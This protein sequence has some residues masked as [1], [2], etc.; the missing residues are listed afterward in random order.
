ME[1]HRVGDVVHGFE[2]ISLEPLEEYQAQGLSFKHRR[3]GCEIFHLFRD[4]PENFFAFVFKTPPPDNA[5]VPHILEHSVLSGSRRYPLKDPFQAMM[6]GSINSF[7]NAMTYSEKTVFPAASPSEKDYFNLF[8]VYA[9]SVFFPLLKKEIFQQEGYHLEWDGEKLNISGIV[10]SEMKGAYESHDTIVGE[11]SYRSLFPDT[12]YQF[13]SGGIPEAIPDLTYEKFLDFHRRC[14]HP[15]NCRVFLYG[16]IPTERQLALLEEEY[17]HEFKAAQW[18]PNIPSTPRWEAPRSFSTTSPL[19]RGE[20]ADGR[21]TIVMS[22]KGPPLRRPE[23]LLAMEVLSEILLGHVGAPLY[24]A[25]V[26]SG[27]GEDV[28]PV[29][30]LDSDLREA[31]FT[32]GLRGGRK[33]DEKTFENL[34]IST[35]T[36]LADGGIPEN[37]LRAG[38]HQVEFRN[39]EI[40][41]GVPFG[42]RLMDKTLPGWLHGG[43]PSEPL[44]FTASMEELKKAL[45]CEEDYFAN[46]IRRELLNNPHRST[47]VIIPDP[48]HQARLDEALEEKMGALR[49]SMSP[50]DFAN[51]KEEGER[52]ARFQASPDDE[53]AAALIPTLHREDLPRDI[54]LIDTSR[55]DLAGIPLYIHDLFTN[56]LVYIDI[57]FDLRGLTDEQALLLPLLSRLLCAA[58]LPEMKY[59][60]VANRLAM[61]SGGLYT[62]LEAGLNLGKPGENRE[63]LFFRLKSLEK[64]VDEALSLVKQLFL[65]GILTDEQRIR[66]ILLEQRNDFKSTIL[67]MG[68]T[69]TVL[70]GGAKL[71]P[72]N[73]REEQWRGV[74]QYLFLFD[75][76]KRLDRPGET[77]GIGAQLENI[78]RKIFTRK[79]MILN[80]T[81]AGESLSQAE[82]KASPF[83]ASFPVGSPVVPSVLSTLDPRGEK[84]IVPASVGYAGRIIPASLAGTETYA[85]E[86][87]AGHY[88]QTNGLWEEVRMKGGAYGVSAA[89]NGADGVFE[90]TSYRDPKPARTF[91]IFRE[92]LAD[93][94]EKAPP[95]EEMERAVIA[96]IG[97]DARPL[98]P[99]EKSLIGFR[100]SLYG[101]TDE[102]RRENR[103]RILSAGPEDLQKTAERLFSQW[104]EGISVLLAGAE[105]AES[106]SE[107]FPELSE[108][109]EIPF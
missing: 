80:I 81:A 79:R 37:L 46:L 44:R 75:T 27:I 39:R 52:L 8:R 50:R 76:A 101:I 92:A 68:H 60:E 83:V 47:V 70:R 57:A 84:L 97:R 13:D 55:K 54:S 41:G 35:L 23:N 20:A 40:K 93:M 53:A 104:E 96:V 18:T 66:D 36:N 85:H 43:K 77:A 105:L 4:D 9:D 15:S 62:S 34:V 14:Y 48:R 78:R 17:L 94:R 64:D 45:S 63:L 103:R 99:G 49:D 21:G 7:L 65:E 59:D 109:Q 61:V 102:M 24:R 87:L 90:F 69:L 86:L 74:E 56:G 89:A 33:E 28:S 6:K 38:L 42:L 73:R 98:S 16:D 2:F 31:V 1:K 32:I 91:R 51:L 11:W 10:Y 3:T 71:S 5:G 30:G 72:A 25:I 100:R 108:R 58:G 88:L 107:A 82:E 95:P 106:A 19:G 29:S 26:E 22:W 12:P 67:P